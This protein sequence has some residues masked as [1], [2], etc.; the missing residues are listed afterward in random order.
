MYQIGIISK[1]GRD[2]SRVLSELSR[3]RF[4]IHIFTDAP[5]AVSKLKERTLNSLV[6]ILDN[7]TVKQLEL[8][9]KIR[10]L[11]ASI[12]MVFVS[13][14]IDFDAQKQAL[15][16]PSVISL[17]I[18]SEIMD[19]NG[20]LVRMNMGLKV[21]NRSDRRQP[22]LQ[23]ASIK[24]SDRGVDSNGCILDLAA[25]GARLRSFRNEYSKGDKIR[26]KI[27]LTFLCKT[28][29]VDAEVV[30]CRKETVTSSH[31]TES[32]LMGLRFLSVMGW[33]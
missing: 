30:W 22:T 23:P 32:Q 6:V 20:I 18:N 25:R 12:P 8:A 5:N 15:K 33:S 19:L 14:N 16:I 24:T 2:L 4:Q 28:Y 11:H 9:D 29:E 26:L 10:D 7:F 17:G 21:W 1:P 3:G 13:S 27:P 31:P